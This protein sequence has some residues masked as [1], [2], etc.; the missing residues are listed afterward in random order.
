M[1]NSIVQAFTLI[2]ELAAL[3]ATQNVNEDTQKL[4]NEHLQ[5]ILSTVVKKAITELSAEANGIII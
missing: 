1:N 4:A 2:R 5:A 3:C